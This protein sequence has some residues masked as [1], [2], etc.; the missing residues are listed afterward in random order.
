[1]K[2]IILVSYLD[3]FGVS[4]LQVAYQDG[5][6]FSTEV[7][8]KHYRDTYW[9]SGYRQLERSVSKQLQQDSTGSSYGI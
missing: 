1:M 9:T 8:H 2:S 6:H 4:E 7:Q 5:S 3:S